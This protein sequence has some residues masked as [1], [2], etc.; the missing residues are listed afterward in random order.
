[1]L[2]EQIQQSVPLRKGKSLIIQY[3]TEEKGI[4][5]LCILRK[6]SFFDVGRGF[7]ADSLRNVYIEAFVG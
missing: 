7:M 6:F 3:K 4:I 5:G 2:H 1:L